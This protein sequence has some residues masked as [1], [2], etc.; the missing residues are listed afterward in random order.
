MFQKIRKNSFRS[1]TRSLDAYRDKLQT[2]LQTQWAEIKEISDVDQKRSKLITFR[3]DVKKAK[4]AFL[5]KQSEIGNKA[6]R[7][8]TRNILL[9]FFGSS[10]L[11]YAAF[12]AVP[13]LG[14]FMIPAVM[15]ASTVAICN[16]LVHGFKW[17]D[18]REK[19]EDFTKALDAMDESAFGQMSQV[20]D[21]VAAAKRAERKSQPQFTAAASSQACKETPAGQSCN[22][23]QARRIS[24]PQL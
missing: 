10:A 8:D 23:G 16:Y 13:A 21:K 3:R 9:T 24:S 6:D 22:S 2:D 11:G 7:K 18:Q 17:G 5:K 1:R 12:L 20:L 4:E 15:G 14:P 19:G